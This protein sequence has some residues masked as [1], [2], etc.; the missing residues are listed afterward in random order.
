MLAA[1]PVAMPRRWVAIVNAA[2]TAAEEAAVRAAVQRGRPVGTAA[3][4]AKAATRLG[5]EGTLRPRGRPRKPE[6][7]KGS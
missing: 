1:W 7:K 6:P 3:W 4:V 2:Q 5:L